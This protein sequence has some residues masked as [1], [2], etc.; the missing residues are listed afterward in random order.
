V[1][2]FFKY[3]EIFE[4]HMQIARETFIRENGRAPTLDELIAML[5]RLN[6]YYFD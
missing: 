3:N 6:F 5:S 2:D 4:D 1:N